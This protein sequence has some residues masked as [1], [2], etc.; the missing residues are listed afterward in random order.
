MYEEWCVCVCV[1]MWTT[2]PHAAIERTVTYLFE[3]SLFAAAEALQH[4]DHFQ[5]D[6]NMS[7]VLNS[8]NV[9]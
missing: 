6:H 2:A 4:L 5:W 1:C 7:G 9:H 8:T 3:E